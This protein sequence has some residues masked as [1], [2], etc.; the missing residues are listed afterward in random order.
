MARIP[1]IIYFFFFCISLY[2][3]DG[4]FWASGNTLFPLNETSIQLKK[5]ILN[6]TKKD[7]WM[8]V[9]IYFEFYNPGN[10]KELTV[11]FVTP[12]AMGDFAHEVKDH[13]QVRDFSVVVNADTMPY[14]ISKTK[15]SGFKLADKIIGN[16]D[17]IYYFNVSFP[18]GIT[19]IKHSYLYRGGE[20]MIAIHSFYYRLTT[21]TSWANKEIED[22]ELNIDMGEDV[23]FSVPYSFN[24]KR[25]EWKVIGTGHINH[26]KPAYAEYYRSFDSPE[27]RMVYIRKGILQYKT[28][29]FKPSN[30]LNVTVYQPDY[31]LNT[32]T[33]NLKENDFKDLL[34]YV[35]PWQ[36][37]DSIRA[38]S[39]N[40]TNRQ[41]K[42]LINLSYARAG[43]DFK[44][45]ELK[46]TFSKYLWYM[47]DASIQQEFREYYYKREV[48]DILLA[49]EKRRKKE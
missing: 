3:N 26:K 16:E 5:E 35:M 7:N 6:L 9:D 28:N 42:L 22:F 45:I 33:Q 25:T 17:F 29:H 46:K 20:G 43:Y 1:F 31:E 37:V 32:W 24:K 48:F 23:Y 10:T 27:L 30:D 41:L 2:A 21:G 13:P 47:P 36:D 4:S 34:E 38:H 8:Q 11:G 39:V 14:N 12:P 44:D 15:K 40:L 18:K 19:K 49:E